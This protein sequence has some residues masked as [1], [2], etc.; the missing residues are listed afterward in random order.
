[1][2]KIRPKTRCIKCGRPV[3]K[4]KADKLGGLCGSCHHAA[5]AIP[6]DDFYIPH[7]LAKRL[8][9]LN[10]NPLDYREMAWRDGLDSLAHYID[11]LSKCNDLYE[12]WFPKLREF[13]DQC[14]AERPILPEK[15]LSPIDRAKQQ[16]YKIKITN[17][18]R[19]AFEGNGVI[20]CCLPLIGIPVAEKLWPGEDDSTILLTP[21]ESSRWDEIYSHP[22]DA[23]WWFIDYSWSIDD[24]PE[25]QF[26]L[27]EN[28]TISYW[29]ENEVPEG[30]FPWLVH[31]GLRWGPLLG[32]HK[33][34][35]WLWD[36]K[37]CKFIRI[38]S[39]IS[40]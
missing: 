9:A 6:P 19:L 32:G 40:F 17:A 27:A 38:T 35:L 28:F 39:H 14:R 25:R 1:M 30:S 31:S 18:E 29:E 11:S 7:H 22:E 4:S 37:N 8:V 13:A 33:I 24:S 21:E 20:F 36:G 26:S 2:P 16:V 10:E 3:L 34:E 12:K 23:L 5:A 15:W